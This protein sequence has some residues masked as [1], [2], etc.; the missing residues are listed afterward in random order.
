MLQNDHATCAVDWDVVY[1][2]VRS[3]HRAV[4]R[5]AASKV[6]TTSE[7]SWYN[8]FS[9]SMPD[10]RSL[11]VDWEQVR[12]RSTAAADADFARIAERATR[13]VRDLHRELKWMVERTSNQTTAFSDR[14][15]ALQS[16]NMARI[17]SAVSSYG[18]Q[19]EVT[20]FVRDTSADGL[21]VGA[22]IMS[23]GAGLAVLGGGSTL[24]GWAKFQDTEAVAGNANAA[25]AAML[26]ATGN[27]MFG[28]FKLGGNKLANSEEAVLTILQAQWETGIALVEGKTLGQAVQSGSLKLAGP[29]VD[30]VFKAAPVARMLER[31]C[32]P[33]SITAVTKNGVENVAT[34]VV[35]KTLT[36]VAQK[37]VVEK[38][39]GPAALRGAAQLSGGG[40]AGTKVHAPVAAP[41]QR[42]TVI[43]SATLSDDTLLTLAIVNM[44]KGIGRGL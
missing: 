6:V 40:A 1:R 5:E 8:P 34:T 16:E 32:V 9:W 15:A 23:G 24:K 33:I 27:F 19:I 26:T 36:K 18:T 30:R 21:M 2:L 12:M 20:K 14:L 44:S 41:S 11:E 13:D 43:E 17:S 42:S 28:A 3:Y 7:S 35:S 38:R 39:A 4:E 37:Q 22:T 10:I 31:A 29:F 25:A